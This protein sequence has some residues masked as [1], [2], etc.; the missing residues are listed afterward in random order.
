MSPAVGGAAGAAGTTR[1]AAGAAAFGMVGFFSGLMSVV[2]PLARPGAL[3]LLHCHAAS[4]HLGLGTGQFG[5][6]Q[7]GAEPVSQLSAALRAPHEYIGA[8]AV[9]A[10]GVARRGAEDGN[11]ADMVARDRH[12]EP[13]KTAALPDERRTD[14]LGAARIRQ[15]LSQR[16]YPTLGRRD[17]RRAQGSQ[18]RAV[19][20]ARIQM[21]PEH[22]NRGSV[23][24]GAG[25]GV[26]ARRR[27]AV[28]IDGGRPRVFAQ[29]VDARPNRLMGEAQ[30]EANR[31]LACVL[32]LPGVEGFLDVH[33]YVFTDCSLFKDRRRN[34]KTQS[35][36][37]GHRL[38]RDKIYYL[39][40]T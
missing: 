9:R 4:R 38:S 13:I 27:P 11:S 5:V 34:Q 1:A 14:E 3:R 10:E 6:G 31:R 21:D 16:L 37:F 28:V 7:P 30:H 36:S 19:L 22:Q 32:C 39:A 15:I 25:Y 40:T 24:K 29:V 26:K 17:G 2:W 20:V 12:P 35:A 8:A 33:P 23:E 18:L